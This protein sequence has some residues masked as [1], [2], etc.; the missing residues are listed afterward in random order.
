[1]NDN[2]YTNSEIDRDISIL[3]LRDLL[4]MENIKAKLCRDI[5]AVDS[6]IIKLKNN[7]RQP[8]ESDETAEETQMLLKRGRMYREYCE[9][10]MMLNN[11]Y[12]VNIIPA[13]LRQ[14]CAVYYLYNYMVSSNESLSAALSYC[15]SN[16][17]VTARNNEKTV[18]K[19]LQMPLNDTLLNQ[20]RSVLAQA[21]KTADDAMSAAQYSQIASIDAE[22]EKWIA[23]ADYFKHKTEA[24]K[25]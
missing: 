9:I 15:K 25:G 16:D 20:S 8:R 12:S 4:F 2:I 23:S 10:L 21:A 11:A 14:I 18:S 6:E 17:I 24:N 13:E 1:M 3:Y 7:Y 22:L 5:N 19:A